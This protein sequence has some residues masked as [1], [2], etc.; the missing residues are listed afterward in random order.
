MIIIIALGGHLMLG[1]A[2]FG[3]LLVYLT[4]ESL[5]F[6]NNP[7]L[8][9]TGLVRRGFSLF[10]FIVYLALEW[11]KLPKLIKAIIMVGPYAMALITIILQFYENMM[12]AMMLVAVFVGLSF[13]VFYKTKQPW[14]YYYAALFALLV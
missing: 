12:T 13:M 11:T 3:Y 6:A 7:Q 8:M 5:F 1:F 14:F 9:D 4:I 10:I 2:Y